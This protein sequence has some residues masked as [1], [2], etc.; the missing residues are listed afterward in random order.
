MG[1]FLLVTTDPDISGGRIGI[2]RDLIDSRLSNKAWPIYERTPNRLRMVEGSR[3]AFYVGGK[4]RDSQSIIATAVVSQ[5][6]RH[7]PG[8]SRPDP[9]EFLTEAP[10]LVLHLRDIDVLETPVIL[11]DV[12]PSLTICP[13]N[14]EKWGCILMGGSRAIPKVDWQT[15][16]GHD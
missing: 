5:V 9:L 7:R 14:M 3:V 2:A 8:A 4:C 11:R 16:F 13:S 10:E 15:L 6:S 1:G 12:L